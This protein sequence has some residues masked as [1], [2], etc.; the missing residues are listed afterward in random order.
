VRQA[1]FTDAG[2][3]KGLRSRV[4]GRGLVGRAQVG[5][6]LVHADLGQDGPVVVLAVDRGHG[7]DHAA[8]HVDGRDHGHAGLGGR[9]D[10][11]VDVAHVL[12]ALA[13]DGEGATRVDGGAHQV[14]LALVQVVAVGQHRVDLAVVDQGGDQL[15]AG[16]RVDL[17]VQQQR[18]LAVHR[19]LHRQE[20]QVLEGP[21]AGLVLD[22]QQG[23]PLAAQDLALAQRV[24]GGRGELRGAALLHVGR[25]GLAEAGGLDAVQTS[26]GLH[27][28]HDGLG[29]VH[30]GGDQVH[31]DV[32][33]VDQLE[34]AVVL[35]AVLV[36]DLDLLE[37][38][39]DGEA[40]HLVGRH[41]LGVAE[42][43][44]GAIDETGQGEGE[45]Q[46]MGV[47]DRTPVWLVS[48]CAFGVI[49]AGEVAVFVFYSERG[50]YYNSI[51]TLSNDYVWI[52]TQFVIID[53][54]L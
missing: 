42:R 34:P 10:L 24:D 32:D 12:V 27:A 2:Q 20:P 52:M 48:R 46:Q 31:G 22:E 51:K 14:V 13:H 3:L 50:K 30:V 26:E 29:D 16:D 37:V 33:G 40:G 41:A 54:I 4:L 45:G 47:H 23:V 7:L 39:V 1:L 5:R 18:V 35:R 44:D 49:P 17:A 19:G 53:Y 25:D 11:E 9:D 15:D 8:V 36:A 43:V 21:V 6:D 38:R 28:D